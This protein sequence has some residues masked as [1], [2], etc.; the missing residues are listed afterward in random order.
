MNSFYSCSPFWARP[1]PPKNS[2]CFPAISNVATVIATPAIK[3]EWTMAL[4]PKM[5]KEPTLLANITHHI[6]A[7]ICINRCRV[8]KSCMFFNG[9]KLWSIIN[10]HVCAISLVIVFSRCD[11]LSYCYAILHQ[12]DLNKIFYKIPILLYPHLL[13]ILIYLG[14]TNSTDDP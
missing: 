6:H 5:K 10:D 8:C 12:M 9:L 1:K 7:N 14:H 13:G 11:N 4:N 2:G 3:R